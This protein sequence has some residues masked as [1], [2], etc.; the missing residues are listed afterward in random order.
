MA[1]DIILIIVLTAL[2]AACGYGLKKNRPEIRKP[3]EKIVTWDQIYKQTMDEI[4][5]QKLKLNVRKTINSFL[6]IY[7]YKYDD[8]VLHLFDA[9]YNKFFP[10][11]THNNLFYNF[12][13][14]KFGESLYKCVNTTSYK[15]EKKNIDHVACFTFF[16]MENKNEF[17]FLIK[18]GINGCFK[19]DDKDNDFIIPNNKMFLDFNKIL[20]FNLNLSTAEEFIKIIDL[21]IDDYIKELNGDK[22]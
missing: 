9:K 19:C 21:I 17:L 8:I 14:L 15:K 22:Q 5:F 18:D 12:H 13:N 20:I 11:T 2:A 1:I 3:K 10:Y 4:E 6:N 16:N 7:E